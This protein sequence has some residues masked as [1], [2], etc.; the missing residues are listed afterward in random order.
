MLRRFLKGRPHT[1]RQRRVEGK[2]GEGWLR[3]HRGEGANRDGVS[4][5]SREEEV[6]PRAAAG[7]ASPASHLPRCRGLGDLVT[8]QGMTSE[9]HLSPPSPPFLSLPAS[10]CRLTS[11]LSPTSQPQHLLS[12]HFSTSEPSQPSGLSS[13]AT[14]LPHNEACFVHPPPALCQRNA[15]LL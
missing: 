10:W 4:A 7:R 11:L 13:N 6:E 15:P 1:G 5:L 8:T 9:C 3:A 14:P 12:L 2:H